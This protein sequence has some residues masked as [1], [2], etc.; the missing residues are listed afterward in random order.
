MAMAL[1]L[2]TAIALSLLG[3]PGLLVQSQS[4]MSD[5]AENANTP[6]PELA[7]AC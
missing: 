4:P 6:E 7:L 3:S 5:E 1:A 2:N